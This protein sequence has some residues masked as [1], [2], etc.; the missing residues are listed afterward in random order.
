MEVSQWGLL[1]N[2]S[3][4][5]SLHRK[6]WP[7]IGQK[8]PLRW[9]FTS[10]QNDRFLIHKNVQR[11]GHNWSM[12]PFDSRDLKPLSWKDVSW[13]SCFLSSRHQFH[14]EIIFGSFKIL[15]SSLRVILSL[16]W[17]D[18]TP[19]IF[20]SGTFW[21]WN[22]FKK[23]LTFIFVDRQTPAKTLSSRNNRW[24]RQEYSNWKSS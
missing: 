7:D 2:L 23:S 13:S 3:R 15:A 19:I 21:S 14:L 17:S 12:T 20:G 5:S 4:T 1:L 22:S 24:G 18:F 9:L 8:Q 6:L 11:E 10:Y 16:I